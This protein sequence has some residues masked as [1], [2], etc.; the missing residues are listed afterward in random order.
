MS[1]ITETTA[2]AGVRDRNR[3]GS[4]LVGEICRV[5]TSPAA[6]HLRGKRSEQNVSS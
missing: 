1:L 2:F 5:V 6:A 4:D 3:R